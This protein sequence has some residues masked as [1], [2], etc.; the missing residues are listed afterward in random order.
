MKQPS[1]I[2][3]LLEYF[4]PHRARFALAILLMSLQ[5]FI[6]ATLVVLIEQVLDEVLISKDA[7]KLALMPFALVGLYLVG[8]VL[9]VGR[10][11][12]TRHIAWEVITR[13]RSEVFWHVLGLDARWHQKHPRGA[14]LARLSQDVNTIEFGVT[15]IVSAIQQPL[16]LVVLLGTAAW[17]NLWLT[18]VAIAVLPLVAWPIAR[19]GRKLR[20]SSQASLDNMAAMTSSVSE[21]LAGMRVVTVF[22]GEDERGAHFEKANEEQRQLQMRAFLARLMPGPVV[23]LIAA[24]GVGAVLWV[25]GRQVFAGEIQA[26]ELIAFMVALGFLNEP[27]KGISK[28]HNLI[29]QAVAG[30]VALFD[31]LDTESDVLDEGT[32]TAPAYPTQLRFEGVHFDYGDRP[33]LNDLSFDVGAG[34]VVALVGA[35]GAG[36]STIASLISRLI[37]PRKGAILLDGSDL[38]DY[39]MSSLRSQIAVVSQDTFLFNDTV[40]ANICFGTTA[41]IAEVEHAARVA[42][43]HDF[44]CELPDGYNTRIDELGLRLSGG[45]RQRICIARAVLRNAPILILDEATSAL[46]SE[47]EALVQEALDRLM[48]DRTVLAIAHRL[49]T[50]RGADQILVIEDGRVVE[51]GVHG[52]LL[53]ASG[54]YAKLIKHQTTGMS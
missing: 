30:A 27:L 9:T 21:T 44:I 37:D 41:T 53:G 12:L 36:K 42:N 10:G 23:E 8:G 26:G 33:V 28:I 51:Q 4:R 45:Q 22:G 13:L 2:R 34:T 1:T 14:T 6:P 7:T 46:D 43:A 49:S 16:T 31:I 52:E 17:M 20:E 54:P 29:Q 47:S 35:S 15:G 18:L 11:M 5:A 48:K 50:V 38:R 32:S 24:V 39:S 3:R 19:F 40:S 25:G